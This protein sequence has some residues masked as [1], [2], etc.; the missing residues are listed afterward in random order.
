[1]LSRRIKALLSPD[2]H[3][4]SPN[5][6]FISSLYFDDEWDSAYYEK[7]SGSSHRRKYR[8]RLY[9]GDTSFVRLECKEKLTD[10]IDKRSA[11]ITPDVYGALLRGDATSLAHEKNELL[12][13]FYLLCATRLLRPRVAVT[14]RREAYLH[15][16][17]NTRITFDKE[18]RAGWT[19]G[20]MCH[21]SKDSFPIFPTGEFPFPNGVILEIKYD[22]QIAS[23]ITDALRVSNSPLA[24]SK[25]VLCRDALHTL[26]KAW[27][28]PL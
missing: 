7:L 6:Y 5:G 9:E 1:M 8:V 14:Y 4:P 2:P 3:M 10:R 20:A 18:L 23:F 13:E 17:S 15:P 12:R 16:L 19:P 11:V 28:M 22:E 24:A 21:Q 25:Y 26:D 27:Q